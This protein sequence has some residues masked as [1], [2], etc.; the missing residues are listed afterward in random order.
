MATRSTLLLILLGAL[1]GCS[2]PF[3]NDT[4]VQNAPTP[5][6]ADAAVPVEYPSVTFGVTEGS[7]I[8]NYSFQG[9]P[10]PQRA[11]DLQTVQLADFYNPHADDPSYMPA[12]GEPDDRFYP[13]GSLYNAGATTPQPKPRA[14][15]IDVASVW[16]G[17]CNQEA[18]DVL[19]GRYAKY[20]PC[21]GQFL[22][23][24]AQGT[25]NGTPATEQNLVAWSNA[26][27]LNYP[28]TIDGLNQLSSVYGGQTFPDEV[29][30]DTRT[31]KL[32]SVVT[33]IPDDEFWSTFEAQLTP[34]CLGH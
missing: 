20:K 30:I 19:P 12:P 33:A 25:N 23:Q 22:F 16:C 4:I 2:D 17:P 21:G 14:L 7:I 5:L 11:R 18:K 31:M 29:I 26:Y 32:V 1:S 3:G 13:P 8:Q 28:A 15:L 34:G 24:L 6:P 9:F 10:D 27:A